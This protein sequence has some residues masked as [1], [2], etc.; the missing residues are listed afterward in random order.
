MPKGGLGNLTALPL[1]FAARKGGNSV[2]IDPDL[3]PYPDQWRFLS[4]IVRRHW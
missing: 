1:Q 2:F 4:M 3:H